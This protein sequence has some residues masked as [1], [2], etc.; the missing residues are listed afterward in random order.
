MDF[1]LLPEVGINVR[2]ALKRLD[3]NEALFAEMLRRFADDNSYREIVKAPE[4]KNSGKLLADSHML[5]G[6]CGILSL[7]PL[8]ELLSRQVDLLRAGDCES[9]AA[10]APKIS[11]CYDEI[12]SAIRRWAANSQQ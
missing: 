2:D 6:L 4:L 8:Y 5:K 9:A 3:G 10:L 11:E 1:T 12:T 7:T